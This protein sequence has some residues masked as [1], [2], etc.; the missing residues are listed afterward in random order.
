MIHHYKNIKYY[1]K[2]T[3]FYNIEERN[4]GDNF[5]NGFRVEKMGGNKLKIYENIYSFTPGIRNVLTETSN[6][7]M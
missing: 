3:G 6:K 2:N 7:P 5:W 4:T 1:E